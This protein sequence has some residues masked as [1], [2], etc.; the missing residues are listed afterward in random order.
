MPNTIVVNRKINSY[1]IDICRLPGNCHFGNPFLLGKDGDRK[2]IIQ[3]YQ[4]WLYGT[5]FREL[6]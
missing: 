4:L 6:E 3:K 2:A 1:D 5:E